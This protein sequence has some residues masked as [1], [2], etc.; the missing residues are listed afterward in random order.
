[1]TDKISPD[2]IKQTSWKWRRTYLFIVTL[3]I[4]LVNGYVII[5]KVD[6]RSADTFVYS[7]MLLLSVCVLSYVFGAVISDTSLLKSMGNKFKTGTKKQDM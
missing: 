1:M 6:T 5:A 7:S 3:F 4:M 2:F